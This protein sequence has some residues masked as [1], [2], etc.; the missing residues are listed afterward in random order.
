MWILVSGLWSPSFQ[1]FWW[2]YESMIVGLSGDAVKSLSGWRKNTENLT[3]VNKQ[4]HN[5]RG[6]KQNGFKKSHR[7]ENICV[8]TE[9]AVSELQMLYLNKGLKWILFVSIAT[10]E[11]K[12]ATTEKLTWRCQCSITVVLHTDVLVFWEMARHVSQLAKWCFH[13]A[14]VY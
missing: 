4:R 9:T 5:K 3:R 7:W 2:V 13:L 11:I 6:A 1:G 12:R 10:R 14:V 8:I